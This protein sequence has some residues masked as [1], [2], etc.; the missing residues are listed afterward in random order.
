MGGG[1]GGLKCQ[2]SVKS[3]AICQ[4]SVFFFGHLA[5]VSKIFGCQ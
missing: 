1:G 2:L 4:L 3:L 5:V